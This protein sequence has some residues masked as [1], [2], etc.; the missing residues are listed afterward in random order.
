MIRR[1]DGRL[2]LLLADDSLRQK[3]SENRSGLHI[4]LELVQ[5][6]AA[7]AKAIFSIVGQLIQS[8]DAIM[9][10]IRTDHRIEDKVEWARFGLRIDLAVLGQKGRHSGIVILRLPSR[11][12]G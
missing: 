6:R 4:R 12:C 7:D 10:M 11:S 5:Q 1:V 8:R 3:M 9:Q 2:E